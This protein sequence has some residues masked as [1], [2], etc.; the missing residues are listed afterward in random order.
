MDPTSYIPQNNPNSLYFLPCFREEVLTIIANLKHCAIGWDSIPTSLIQDNKACVSTCLTHIIN[1]SLSQGIFPAEL[2]IA[3]L[4]P[5]FKSG[6]SNEPGNYRPIS[7]L[8]IFSK[9]FQRIVYS[10]LSD[11]F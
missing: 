6:D 1:L 9:I 3:I 4:V 2:K 11:F 8:T 10:R 7:L 5:I